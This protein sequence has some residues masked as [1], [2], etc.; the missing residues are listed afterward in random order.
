M[1]AAW[2]T[3]EQYWFIRARLT[4]RSRRIWRESEGW[5]MEK[6]KG[7][8]ESTQ[9]WSVLRS[10]FRISWQVSDFLIY[11]EESVT[12]LHIFY[13]KTYNDKMFKKR[14]SENKKVRIRIRIKYFWVS[15]LSSKRCPSSNYIFNI[16]NNVSKKYKYL[17]TTLKPYL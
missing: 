17:F 8:G 15:S 6:K 10:R 13:L 1:N 5:M 16:L 2:V 11:V 7:G 3:K 9:T 14:D 4:K 12:I